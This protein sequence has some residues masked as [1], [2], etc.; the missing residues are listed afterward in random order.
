MTAG[1]KEIILA[2]KNNMNDNRANFNWEHLNFL[3]CRLPQ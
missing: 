3:E 2:A 1:G